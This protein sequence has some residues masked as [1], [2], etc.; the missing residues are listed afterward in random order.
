MD[1]PHCQGA[2]KLFSN[3][4]ANQDLREYR[5]H[6]PGKTTRLLIDALKSAGIKGLTLLD[7]GGGV[8]VIQHELLKN[9]VSSATAVDASSAYLQTAQQEAK[10]QGH[11]D[12]VTY[13]HGD[14]VE[15]APQL[16]QADIVTLEKVLCCYPDLGALVNLSSGRARKFYGVVFPRDTWW[17]KI[18]G[19]LINLI[20]QLQRNP[21]RFFVH[22]TEEIEA[23]LRANGLERR[24]Y[25][26]TI[27]WQVAV[28]GR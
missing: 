19:R 9:E 2:D 10:R 26:R 16:P 20:F 5:S 23:L 11:A 18:G 17:M 24:Y 8:G 27:F 3:D 25:D 4:R 21:F 7:I 6:G 1:C 13:H 12:R 14:F 15:L 22:R 28:Y